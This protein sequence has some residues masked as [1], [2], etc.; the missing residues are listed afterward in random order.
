MVTSQNHQAYV[1]N[2][3]EI[4][5]LEA[6]ANVSRYYGKVLFFATA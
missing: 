1:Q 4:P 5:S 3:V 6:I 2:A